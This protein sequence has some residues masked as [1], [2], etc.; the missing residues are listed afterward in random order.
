MSE[1]T[2]NQKLK[3]LMAE[4]FNEHVAIMVKAIERIPM[5][6]TLR[7]YAN[8]NFDQFA[9]WVRQAIGMMPENE[10]SD[11][12]SSSPSNLEMEEVDAA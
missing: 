9:Y 10:S 4:T 8:M 1:E 5:H 6:P 3:K 7:S 2:P 11:H 12:T